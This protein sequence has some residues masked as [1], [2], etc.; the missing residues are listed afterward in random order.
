[1]KY[2]RTVKI[3][4]ACA[5]WAAA[6]IVLVRAENRATQQAYYRDRERWHPETRVSQ[7]SEELKQPGLSEAKRAEKQQELTAMRSV[8]SSPPWREPSPLR[9]RTRSYILAVPLLLIGVGLVL[10]RRKKTNIDREPEH[11]GPANR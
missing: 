9:I 4:M 7:L 11:V 3:V 6:V 8:L 2:W 10:F 1:M 5:C